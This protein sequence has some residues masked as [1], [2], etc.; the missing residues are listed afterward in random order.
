MPAIRQ[1]PDTL[2]NQIAAGEVV[3]RPAAALKELIENA[4]DAGAAQ[5]EVELENGG[6]T[7]LQVRDDGIGIAR[8]DLPLALSRHATSKLPT[9]NLDDLKH[10][11]FRGEALP[12]IA[13]VSRLNLVSRARG[14]DTAWKI[15]VAGGQMG[16][17]TP[18]SHPTG[19]TVTVKDLFYATPA[20]LKFLKSDQTEYSACKDVVQRLAMAA[21][22]VGFRLRH[23]GTQILNLPAAGLA[24]TP[25]TQHIARILSLLGQD[26][27]DNS[28]AVDLQRDATRLYGYASLPTYNKGNATSQ[29]VF[30]NGRAVRDRVLQGA[31]RAA[32]S[33]VLPA[34]RHAHA[35]LYITLPAALVDV[36]V[37]PAKS[38]VRFQDATHIRGLIVGGLRDMLHQAGPR[39]STTLGHGTLHAFRPAAH[40][41]PYGGGYTPASQSTFAMQARFDEPL[42]PQAAPF[43]TAQADDTLATASYPLGAALAHIHTTYILAQT[44]DGVVLIDAH[45]AH[46]RLVYE[47]MKE[48]M[49]ATG[50]VRQALLT[51]E[52]VQ[53]DEARCAELLQ[54][55][56]ILRDYGI[57]IESFGAGAILIRALP[58]EMKAESLKTL[59]MDISDALEDGKATD[60][61][62]QRILYRLATA[63]CH[64]AIRSGR[65]LNA[66]E[67][68][69]LLR[70]MERTPL[71]SQCNHGRPTH[72]TLSLHDIERLFSRR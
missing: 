51:P 71:S 19:S 20:R 43:A 7:L 66:A 46:E 23:N 54:H 67:M 35:V 16:Q 68:N 8:D 64:G 55:Q 28:I 25:E 69:T 45:A 41:R 15:D 17:P 33:D 37:H 26:F 60:P 12:S 22:H 3:E 42:P 13:A 2:I 65:P 48:Q 61:I 31:L 30:V 32:Y 59:L 21:P 40:T 52:I 53:M 4:L 44:T 24:D 36:N 56:A 47:R 34:D 63:A 5:I 10:L 58:A 9:D 6:R 18:A 39:T 72:I 1:L 38:E 57:E 27:I 70:D 14:N 29:Y 50:I 62:E 11:G 49:A